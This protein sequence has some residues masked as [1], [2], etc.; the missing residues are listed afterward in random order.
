[1]TK[2]LLRG[3]AGEN[4]GLGARWGAARGL[5]GI[6]VG[7]GAEPATGGTGGGNKAVREW[8]GGGLKPLGEMIEREDETY[9]GE[10]QDVVREIF[11]SPLLVL[12]GVTVDPSLS[13]GA[14]AYPLSTRSD[15]RCNRTS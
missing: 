7:V 4:R 10:R 12:P 2:T 8:I 13:S 6:V 11:V 5:S 3:L 14:S 9:E 1:M 15:Q